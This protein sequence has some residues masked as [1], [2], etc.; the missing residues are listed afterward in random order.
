MDLTCKV[1]GPQ[2]VEPENLSDKQIQSCSLSVLAIDLR[3]GLYPLCNKMI[4]IDFRQR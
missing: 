4:L 1:S 3:T 2:A